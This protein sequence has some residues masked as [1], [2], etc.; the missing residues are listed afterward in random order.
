VQTTRDRYG[1]SGHKIDTLGASDKHFRYVRL[2]MR[3]P[4]RLGLEL[5]DHHAD[6]TNGDK[7]ALRPGRC[8][9]RPIHPPH[10]YCLALFS[11]TQHES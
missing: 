10:H 11:L 1:I 6:G 3:C 2:T 4:V 5:G 9:Q 8:Q 7:R